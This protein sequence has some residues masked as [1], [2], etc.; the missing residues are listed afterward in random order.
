MKGNRVTDLEW[1]WPILHVWLLLQRW[2]IHW[3]AKDNYVRYWD[4]LVLYDRC[5]MA[6]S[7]RDEALKYLECRHANL[8]LPWDENRG[9][10][11]LPIP[12]KACSKSFPRDI[13]NPT[14]L[15]LTVCL[16][17]LTWSNLH[18]TNTVLYIYMFL[19]NT[20]LFLNLNQNYR[21]DLNRTFYNWVKMQTD[22]RKNLRYDSYLSSV[23]QI[24]TLVFD[25]IYL[26]YKW[27]SYFLVYS[28][29][30]SLNEWIKLIR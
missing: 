10:D 4:S 27:K 12:V 8:E 24:Q 11:L 1:A 6:L 29:Q 5:Q 3:A 15:R 21:Q 26:D 16:Y 18:I 13:N 30:W 23:I 22:I 28:H 9:I 2:I 17:W 25:F 20:Y 19:F 7:H 14:G